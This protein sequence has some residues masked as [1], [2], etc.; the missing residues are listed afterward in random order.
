[1]TTSDIISLV[2][3]VVTIGIAAIALWQTQKQI[4]LSNKQQL[5]ER[6][7]NSYS[8]LCDL[9]RLAKE[10]TEIA[11]DDSL[12]HIP[13]SILSLFVNVSYLEECANVAKAPLEFEP[14]KIFLTKCEMLLSLAEEAKFIWN[15]HVSN[16]IEKFFKSYREFLKALHRQIIALPH[17]KNELTEIS[18]Y[19]EEQKQNIYNNYEELTKV[20]IAKNDLVVACKELSDKKVIEIIEKQISL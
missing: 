17:I 6:R 8:K 19:S 15:K 11:K 3:S 16:Y 14:K 5:F 4:R 20:I 9:Y 1:M 18:T 7:I 10:N 12:L 13:D 2:L